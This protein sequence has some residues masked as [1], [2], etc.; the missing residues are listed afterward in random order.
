MAGR[1]GVAVLCTFSVSSCVCA[2]SAMKQQNGMVLIPACEATVGTSGEE[3]AKL[4]QRFDCHPTW[5]NDDLPAQSVRLPAF[6]LDRF[7]V[8]NAQ[9]LAFVKATGHAPPGWWGKAFPAESGS[10]PVVGVSGKDAIAF[11]Q[12]AGKR[13]P[14]AEEWEAAVGAGGRAPFAWGEEWPGPLKL[15]RVDRP[16]WE[17]P[18]TRPVGTGECGRSRSGIEDFAGQALEW[19]SR[20]IPHHGVQFQLMKGASWF[21]EDP[22]SF[23]TASGWYAHEGWRSAFTGFRCAL[24]GDK[25]PQ[26]VATADPADAPSAASILERLAKAV[27]DGPIS[28]AAAG[29]ASRGVT[30]RAPRLGH[31]AFALS[32]PETVVWNGKAALNWFNQ[33]DMAWTERTPQRA[34]YEMRFK[35][36]TL[37]AEFVARDD[38]AEQ[39]F[40]ATNLTDGPATFR[41]SSCFNLQGHPMLYDLEQRRTYALGADGKF[42][43]MRRL[44]RGGDC[45]HWIT[46]PAPSEL[47]GIPRWALLAVVA[48]DGQWVVASGRG[49]Q[50]QGY[51][52]A[53]NA[54]FTCLHTD[55]AVDVPPRGTATSR[56][57]FYFLKGSLDE[58]AR[59]FRADFGLH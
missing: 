3:R 39:V 22:V 31:E 6:W 45:I 19:V 38:C 15:R 34:A 27:A 37:H 7:P 47:G 23:R 50:G 57:R 13:L 14:A 4:A 53:T 30:L 48:R 18:A 32:A 41:T 11:A 33:P 5:L 2:G 17:L 55:S 36:F 28:L 26:A 1:L 12:W 10:H 52:V 20:V 43:P 59:R 40:T 56:Q 54:L 24:D 8:T 51:A 25:S 44:S 35:E 29:G 21:H 16:L 49:G 9:Y 46:G 42:V 58:L